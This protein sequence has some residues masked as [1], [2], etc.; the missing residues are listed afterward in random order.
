MKNLSL[1]SK[2]VFLSVAISA[3]TVSATFIFT[4]QLKSVSA[5]ASAAAEVKSEVDRINNAFDRMTIGM[6]GYILDPSN[7]DEWA[8]KLKADEDA[9]KSLNRAQSLAVNPTL[10]EK[11]GQIAELDEKVMNRVENEFGEIV[12]QR[13]LAKATKFYFDTYLTARKKM[14]ESMKEARAIAAQD[15]SLADAA[16]DRVILQGSWILVGVI[17]LAYSAFFVMNQALAGTLTQSIRNLSDRLNASVLSIELASKNTASASQQIATS[18]TE[19]ASAI[20]ETLSISESGK[21][22]SEKGV[23]VVNRMTDAMTQVSESNARLEGL[24]KVIEDIQSK[25]K[26]INDIVFE[27]RLLSFNASIEAARAGVHGKGF[28][29]VAEEVGKL[30]A[31]SGKA[32]EEINALLASSTHQVREIVSM[33]TQRVTAAK[34]SS[35]ECEQVFSQMSHSMSEINRAMT[36]MERE[37]HHNSASS[38]EMANQAQTLAI[39]A[40]SLAGLLVKL[41]EILSGK[42]SQQS[43]TSAGGGGMEE[44]KVLP[45]SA[46]RPSA[47]VYAPPAAADGATVDRHDSRW[48]AA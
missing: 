27:T 38:E 39:E 21:K 34:D 2:I 24:I 46:A 5:Q 3:V 11:L 16:E 23:G 7:Q 14:D 6:R 33:T 45:F 12:K 22:E 40:R 48:K 9:V 18:A 42:T 47:P 32:A 43:T 26:V 20:T 29:V 28:A 31:V 30:A 37:T 4:S 35:E 17:L 25:T 41:N 13:N 19:N 1:K 36:D 15:R 8:N 44:A 10:K